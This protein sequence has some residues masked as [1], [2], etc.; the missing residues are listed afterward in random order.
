MNGSNGANGAN[1]V[2]DGV[3]VGDGVAVVPRRGRFQGVINIVRFNAPTYVAAGAVVVVGVAAAIVGGLVGSDAVVVVGAVAAVAAVVLSVGSL[4]GSYL[5]YDA[6]DLYSWACLDDVV[7]ADVTHIAHVHT[8]LDESTNGLRA[9]FPHVDVVV[10]DASDV[11]AQPEPSIARARRIVP[12]HADTVAVGLGPLPATGIDL[13]LLPMAAHEVRDDDARARWLRA[14]SS[15]L[16]PGG[17]VVLIEHLRDVENTVAFH[18][19]VLHFLSARTWRRT[20]ANAGLDVVDERAVAPLLRRF[21][22]LRSADG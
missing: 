11:A 18:V 3:D 4:S 13:I 8:G 6:S 19:G 17:K 1:G 21:V 20:F 7:G 10:Y 5:A 12:L 14:L 16:S 22:L 15:S 2:N 9:R